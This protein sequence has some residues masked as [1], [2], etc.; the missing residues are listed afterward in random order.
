VKNNLRA[1]D[2][3]GQDAERL[4]AFQYPIVAH[5][6]AQFLSRLINLHQCSII[7]Q[8]AAVVP[9]PYHLA[10][11]TCIDQFCQPRNEKSAVGFIS[12]YV[13]YSYTLVKLWE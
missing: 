11:L 10:M 7:E 9:V 6:M 5:V 13:I 1:T 2:R 3:K 12:L 8:S 4:I